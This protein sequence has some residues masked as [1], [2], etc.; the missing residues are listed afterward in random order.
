[1]AAYPE[2][3]IIPDVDGYP[4]QRAPTIILL[5]QNAPRYGIKARTF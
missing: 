3:T 2:I 1:M 5:I 4:G